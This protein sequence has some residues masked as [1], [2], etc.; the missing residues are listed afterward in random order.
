MNLE[1][2]SRP[3]RRLLVS[4]AG[5]PLRIHCLALLTERVASPKG[6][7]DELGVDLTK[8]S[9]H[10]RT[11]EEMGAIE[12]VDTRQVR[13]AIEHFYKAVERPFLDDEDYKTMTPEERID[14]ARVV[15]QLGIADLQRSMDSGVLGERYDHHV[16]RFPLQVDEEGWVELREIFSDALDKTFEVEARSA[17][18]MNVRVQKDKTAARQSVSAEAVGIPVRV[19][20]NVI[21]VPRKVKSI[22]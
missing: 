20:V 13:G 5:H 9:Y 15:T 11:L 1:K 8:L 17:E 21:E 19:L 22:F 16:S 6:L 4:I 10:I 7:A 14:F 2:Q 18:R 3:V 12:L